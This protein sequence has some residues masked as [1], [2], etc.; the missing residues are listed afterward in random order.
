M[1]AKTEKT[2]VQKRALLRSSEQRKLEHAFETLSVLVRKHLNEEQAER[3][4]QELHVLRIKLE[5]CI[6]NQ[7]I[8]DKAY[9]EYKGE[10]F[11]AGDF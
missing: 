7:H 11:N 9:A 5:F 10:R 1:K 2:D 6:K 8:F 4:I 3:E